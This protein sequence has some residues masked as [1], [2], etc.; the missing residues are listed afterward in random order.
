MTRTK[1][2]QAAS[3]SGPA[4]KPSSSRGS[5]KTR[6]EFQG[7]YEPGAEIQHLRDEIKGMERARAKAEKEQGGLLSLFR[8]LREAV[9][10]LPALKPQYKRPKR[11][12]KVARPIVH[13]SHWTDWHYGAVEDSE[14]LEGF[15][16][17]NPEI[18]E[19]RLRNCVKDQ[20]DW[21]ELHRKNYTVHNSHDLFT[22]D[23]ISGGI[24]PELLRTNAWPE[25]VQAIKAGEL[26]AEV[27]AM[28]APHFEQ[29]VV[30]F[31]TADNHGRLTRKPQCSEAGYNNWGYVTACHAKAR[32][33]NFLNVTFNIH[34][35]IQKVVNVGGRRYL[36]THGDRVR[37]WSGFPYYG[38]QTKV[39][40]EHTKRAIQAM[41]KAIAMAESTGGDVD[42]EEAMENMCHLIVM[43][44]WHAPLTHPHFWIGGSA[45]G[46]SAYDHSEGREAKPIQ[47]AW[48]V[49]P[50]HG[51]FD[52]TNWILRTDDHP[53]PEKVKK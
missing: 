36:L 21:V 28:K 8:D 9:D 53:E 43:G 50:K 4:H 18:C 24:H 42:I 26:V 33:A 20:L 7:E 47:C 10:A 16:E 11:K 25:P 22:G 45:S 30:D 32:L 27:I 40:R 34:P 52:R 44:H 29:V 37:G 38:I 15:N 17:F 23:L 12:T 3:R 49:H 13:V 1:T 5:A 48:F 46:T 19:Q 35:L 31:I 39:G 2:S 41:E 14:E 6:A 51:E